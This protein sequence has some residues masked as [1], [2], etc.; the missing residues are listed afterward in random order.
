MMHF[1]QVEVDDEVYQFVKKHAEPLVDSFNSTLK[2][3]LPL[4]DI[5]VKKTHADGQETPITKAS[6]T[7]APLPK[8]IPQELRHIIEVVL[9]VR[10]GAYSRTLATRYVA[11]RY[12]VFPQT[13]LD[14]YCRQLNLTT[15]QFDKLLE[16]SDLRELREILKSKFKNHAQVVDEVLRQ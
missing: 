10:G 13:V 5:Q 9:L 6:S 8:H 12:N 11:K 3:L 15:N 1:H 4:A 7:I 14:K 16:E 2:R